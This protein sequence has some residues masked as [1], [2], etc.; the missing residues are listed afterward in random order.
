MLEAVR[1]QMSAA[2][3][4]GGGEKDWSIMAE[5]VLGRPEKPAA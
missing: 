3:D 4:A 2:V 5:L 1:G